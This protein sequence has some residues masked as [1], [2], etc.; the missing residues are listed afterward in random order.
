MGAKATQDPVKEYDGFDNT[1]Y[2]FV[3]RMDKITNDG[4]YFGIAVGY[5]DTKQ[6]RII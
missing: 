5:S 3:G 1:S 2:G 4:N 6:I